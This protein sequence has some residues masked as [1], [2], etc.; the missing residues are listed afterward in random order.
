MDAAPVGVVR[1][2]AAGM[3]RYTNREIERIC[4]YSRG[5][6]VNTTVEAILPGALG[7]TSTTGLHLSASRKDGTGSPRMS[8]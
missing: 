6:L 3:I 7:E 4:S 2:D 5:E 8:A 1:F